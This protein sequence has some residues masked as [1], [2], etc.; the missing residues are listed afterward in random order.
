LRSFKYKGRF[1]KY[2][3]LN[4]P[5]E[6]NFIASACKEKCLGVKLPSSGVRT[7]H[8]DTMYDFIRDHLEDGFIMIVF[9][10]TNDN[11]SE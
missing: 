2:V 6:N 9:V 7:R 5:A 4:D 1:V 8:I 11:D 3:R 10:K